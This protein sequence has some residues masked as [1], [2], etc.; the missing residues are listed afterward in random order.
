[1][2]TRLPTLLGLACL[3]LA[4]CSAGSTP[5]A[6]TPP[7]GA[8]ET[9]SQSAPATSTGSATAAPTT[10]ATARSSPLAPDDPGAYVH[11]LVPSWRPVGPTVVVDRRPDVGN[12]RVITA[13]AIGGGAPVDLVAL[14]SGDGDW[15]IRPDGSAIVTA[16]NYYCA[17]GT[18]APRTSRLAVIDLVSGAARWLMADDASQ[19]QG[20]P[21][22]SADGMSLF[23]GATDARA[24]ER[25]DLGIFR[26]RADGTGRARLTEP[27]PPGA[28]AF[29]Q[30]YSFAMPQRVTSDGLL[31]WIAWSGDRDALRVRDLASGADRA[32]IA[33]V[34]CPRVAAVRSAA[35][36]ALVRDD[37]CQSP[38]RRLVLWD[39]RT[40]AETVLVAGPVVY[41]A[42]WDPAG[43]RIVAAI[44]SDLASSVS[45]LVMID[46]RDR[47]PIRDTERA[48]SVR[49][50]SGGIVYG[51]LAT[52][53]SADCVFGV[54]DI[55]FIPNGGAARTIYSGC[56]LGPVTPVGPGN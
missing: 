41:D 56:A 8:A 17:G 29:G 21:R 44:V 2:E 32:F 12:G 3:V 14:A 6:P 5:T 26:V 39:V 4:A 45:Q 31:F 38:S 47:T 28:A 53:S 42:D 10:S 9:A 13:V 1:M 18:C 40:G 54:S 46:G 37:G 48:V 27:L 20:W 43:A 7:A 11:V 30:H 23:Y 36:A 49:W 35:P 19:A 52:P 33:Q 51:T 34:D 22:W 24:S 50:L 25:T 16:I 55:R 15:D